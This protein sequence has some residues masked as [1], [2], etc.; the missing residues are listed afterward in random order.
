MKKI[1]KKKIPNE[2]WAIMMA[3]VVGLLLS[4]FNASI[5]IWGTVLGIWILMVLYELI[6]LKN[7]S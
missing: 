3:G 5:H 6:D 2:I 4:Y 7:N 1:N